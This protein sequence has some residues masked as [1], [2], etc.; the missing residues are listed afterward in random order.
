MLVLVL[1]LLMVLVLLLPVLVL[2]LHPHWR[3][4]PRHYRSLL[5]SW[6]RRSGASDRGTY[7]PCKV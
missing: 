5:R 7:L 3:R 4:M 6:H 2:L 1:I